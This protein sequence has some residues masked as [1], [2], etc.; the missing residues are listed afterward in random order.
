MALYT[1]EQ[2]RQIARS[3]SIFESREFSTRAGLDLAVYDIFLSHSF[4]DADLVRGLYRDL[5]RK[6]YTVYVDWIVDPDLD[7]KK[8]TRES[9]KRVRMRLGSCK[10]L[11]LAFSANAE[12]SKW[13]P[14]ELGVVDGRSKYCGIVPV[15]ETSSD[16]YERSEYLKLYPVLET[17][18]AFDRS[19]HRLYV[20]EGSNEYVELQGWLQ[21]ERPVYHSQSIR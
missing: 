4:L 1:K 3:E 10:S 14:W 11:L 16:P 2:L 13:V 9:A 5:R 12:L 7:R 17:Y 15:A 18:S 20:V 19:D 21:G 6:G 8:V